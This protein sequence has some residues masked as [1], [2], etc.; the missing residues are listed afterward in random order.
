MIMKKR[1]GQPPLL[2][3]LTTIAE[4]TLGFDG[5]LAPESGGESFLGSYLRFAIYLLGSNG[6]DLLSWGLNSRGVTS[7]GT[8]FVSIHVYLGGVI[9]SS[10]SALVSKKRK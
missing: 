5:R 8:T 1:R 7:G 10:I 9:Y 6:N 4:P 3:L 2:F